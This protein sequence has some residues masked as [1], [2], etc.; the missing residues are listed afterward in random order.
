ML[1][2]RARI[3]ILSVIVNAEIEIIR[4]RR[5][6]RSSHRVNSGAAYRTRRKSGTYKGIIIII[7]LVNKVGIVGLNIRFD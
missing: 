1:F 3:I 4:I 2:K 5:V 7:I 6:E